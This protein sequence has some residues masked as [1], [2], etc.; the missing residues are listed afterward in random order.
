MEA[1]D[2]GNLAAK[3]LLYTVLPRL[4]LLGTRHLSHLTHKEA[5]VSQSYLRFL[6]CHAVVEVG[7]AV[8][9]TQ[10]NTAHWTTS[11]QASKQLYAGI[12]QA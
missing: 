9:T 8:Q 4:P 11:I 5:Q 1:E 10:M 12:Q 3:C 6:N 7:L 2:D